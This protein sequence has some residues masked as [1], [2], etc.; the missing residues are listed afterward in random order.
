[1]RFK[2]VL[3][4]GVSNYHVHIWNSKII[5]YNTPGRGVCLKI[6]IV[7]TPCTYPST[8]SWQFYQHVRY[9]YRLQ[10]GTL[11]RNFVSFFNYQIT[12]NYTLT[13]SHHNYIISTH[14]IFNKTFPTALNHPNF[15]ILTLWHFIT[16]KCI[17]FLT[18]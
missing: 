16:F 7:N 2:I 10:N 6:K 3:P 15:F 11:L 5:D 8:L 4:A 1:M 18:G 12:V 13:F 14:K 9:H 17:C